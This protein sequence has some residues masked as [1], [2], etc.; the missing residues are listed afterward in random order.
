MKKIYF[1]RLIE[2]QIKKNLEVMGAVHITGPKFCG[3]TTTSMQFQ[4]SY[5][6]L[7]NYE[8]MQI[9][10]I[11]S[12]SIL[13]G[14]NPRL[15]D[16]WQVFPHLW[17]LI[18]NEIDKRS[19]PGL[20]IL[21]GSSTPAD[22]SQIYHSGAGRIVSIKMRPMS[23]Y[24]SGESAG[25][26]SLSNLFNNE[27]SQIFFIDN[28]ESSLENIAYYIC[29]GGW[30]YSV[31]Q[32][33][34]KKSLQSTKNYIDQVIKFDFLNEKRFRK[35]NKTLLKILLESFA[36]NISTPV[37][38][39]TILEDVS[40]EI[41]YEISLQSISKYSKILYD[42]FFL[43][44]LE[45]WNPNYRSSI[46]IRS[47]PVRHFVDPSIACHFLKLSPKN[48]LNDIKTF[49]LIFEDFAVRDLRIYAESIDGSLS[50]YRE[51]NGL[52]CDAVINLNDG[53]YGLIEIKLGGTAAIEKGAKSLLKV[54]QRM[55]DHKKRLPSF[56]MI[57]TSTGIA[58]TRKDGILVVPINLLKP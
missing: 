18:R 17:D 1:D 40:S 58:Y 15:I 27:D 37:S 48:L 57:L 31:I 2:S 41:E 3:K 23:L 30:P 44:D 11:D 8:N 24:E 35:I 54:K 10:Q 33:D 20:F 39:K 13:K 38:I 43:E 21:S 46:R 7:A 55:I 53:R 6:N 28:K 22:I 4:N 32:N 52:E 16:E 47:T 45:P 29:R 50:H 56:L 5:I 12:A 36:R 26:I 9:S 51:S 19:L 25:K 49:E 42:N 14:E 34:Y